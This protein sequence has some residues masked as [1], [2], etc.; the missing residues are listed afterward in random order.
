MVSSGYVPSH[1]MKACIGDV[2]VFA[3]RRATIIQWQ[4]SLPFFSKLTIP[5]IR[6]SRTL[7]LHGLRS[8]YWI[9]RPCVARGGERER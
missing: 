2:W 6:F 8:L 5:L 1:E 9:G 7:N 3:R 4:Y